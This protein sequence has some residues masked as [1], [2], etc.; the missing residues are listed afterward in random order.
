MSEMH[1][2]DHE[3]VDSGSRYGFF[4]FSGDTMEEIEE[5]LP[6]TR[7]ATAGGA[8]VAVSEV[9]AGRAGA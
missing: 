6:E 7:E 2:P 9:A 5:Y 1:A 3:I 4:I 8:A